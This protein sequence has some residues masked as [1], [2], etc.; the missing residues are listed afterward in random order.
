[1]LLGPI[2]YYI[3]K[4]SQRPSLIPPN[5]TAENPGNLE[6]LAPVE[7]AIQSEEY[8][9]TLKWALVN[10]KIKN[11][12]VTGPYGSGKSSV[13][14]S[15][16]QM[17]P[18]DFSFLEISL[19]SFV[20]ETST[21][22]KGENNDDGEV[23]P[24]VANSNGTTII[25]ERKKN[26]NQQLIEL[27][28]LQQIFYKVDQGSIPASRFRRIGIISKELQERYV[29]GVFALVVGILNLVAPKII[30]Q[31]SPVHDFSTN[32]ADL[33]FVINLLLI[34]PAGVWLIVYMINFVS[35][36]GL[37]KLNISSGEI[38]IDPKS[39]TSILN[40]YLD[41]LIYFFSVTTFNVLVIEDMDRFND[42]EIFTKLRELNTLLNSSSQIK[43]RIVFVYAIRDDLFPDERTRTKFFDYII[44]II[45]VINWS[46][47]RQKLVEKLAEQ[48]FKIDQR[49]ITSI[50]LYID[51]M[52]LLKNIF[53]E[54]MLYKVTLKIPK[55]RHTKLLAM[56]VY[57]NMYPVDFSDLHGGKGIVLNAFEQVETSRTDYV[58]GLYVAIKIK[59][60]EIKLIEEFFP[61]SLEQLRAPYL[62]GA[63]D[64]CQSFYYFSSGGSR[65]TFQAAMQDDFF[66]KIKAGKDVTYY[67][68]S[69]GESNASFNFA[70]IEAAVAPNET[71]QVRENRL[72]QKSENS[73]RVI[74]AEIDN[75]MKEV[76]QTESMRLSV[77]LTKHPESFPDLSED[78]KLNRLLRYL[79]VN[80]YIDESYPYLISYFYPG[81]IGRADMHFITN[82]NDR[83]ELPLTYILEK[84]EGLIEMLELP[85]FDK[86]GILNLTIVETLLKSNRKFALQLARLATLFDGR[87]K[88]AIKFIDTFLK[89]GRQIKNFIDFLI[90]YWPG[91][92]N[93]FDTNNHDVKLLFRNILN[94]ANTKDLVK[95]DINGALK[96]YVESNYTI[97]S[98]EFSGD[99][100]RAHAVLKY[101]DIKFKHAR[102]P[103]KPK[104]DPFFNLIC[105]NNFY[106]LNKDNVTEVLYHKANIPKRESRDQ[107]C[108][109]TF[110]QNSKYTDLIAYTKIALS[111]FVENIMLSSSNELTDDELDIYSLLNNKQQL[112]QSQRLGILTRE[113]TTLKDL[114]KINDDDIQQAALEENKISADWHNILVWY[115]KESEIDDVLMRYL[116][117][118]INSK[119]LGNSLL[120]ASAQFEQTVCEELE[121][122]LVYCEGLSDRCYA[123]L[124][125]S[126]QYEYGE[127]DFDLISIEKA[128][129]LIGNGLLL[130]SEDNFH[131]LTKIHQGL[132]I[133]LVAKQ[134]DSYL[135]APDEFEIDNN[136]RLTLLND[137]SINMNNRLKLISLFTNSQLSENSA[138]AEKTLKILTETS[139]LS[140]D[141]ERVKVLIKTA[142]DLNRRLLLF[143]HYLKALSAD[144]IRGMLNDLGGKYAQ[145]NTRDRPWFPLNDINR[146]IAE[147]L[148]I[149]NVIAGKKIADEKNEIRMSGR[150][151]T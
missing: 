9:R 150:T 105:E 108:G 58:N 39:D 82:L 111:D 117:Q 87:S 79:L 46:N 112:T 18:K 28:V 99:L 98:S 27:S 123:N 88:R 148:E 120:K 144:V 68:P 83:R 6:D 36:V 65:I 42:P 41:E 84:P 94:F 129:L 134:I 40:K 32:Y 47:S 26:E 122:E 8:F 20:D 97:V 22:S 107:K 101:L 4:T 49:F 91:V 10:P 138:L 25:K 114:G 63:A 3:I 131:K 142:T 23:K 37:K 45:P 147:Q 146:F 136:D 132:R 5:P 115:T 126:F 73:I 61:E 51:D 78:N 50:T 124:L 38:E 128:D 102:S 12:A 7:D 77:M 104:T 96:C 33:F 89:Q 116:N 29:I 149:K 52:R 70:E 141:E 11:I 14:K 13:L 48:N 109:F 90:Q 2:I 31:F 16:Q 103:I 1:L 19:A 86:D 62:L 24:K 69:Y 135:E 85:D 53:N 30:Q 140:M 151:L 100:T 121:K 93:Y 67:R 17:F 127:F 139:T 118:T 21:D 66:N 106:L 15:F 56:I 34:I 76:R 55:E 43:R 133:K 64:R 35:N 81:K 59:E 119:A 54:L 44:P 92:F 72:K 95:L 125:A 137:S 60:N 80:R 145:L 71:Y 143:T 113:K 57:K 130:L 75:L 110:V 74:Q